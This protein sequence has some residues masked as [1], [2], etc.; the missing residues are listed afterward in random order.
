MTYFHLVASIAMVLPA[1][2]ATGGRADNIPPEQAIEVVRAHEANFLARVRCARWNKKGY[3]GDILNI[4]DPTQ[5]RFDH[6][7]KLWNRTKIVFEPGTGRYRYDCEGVF[8]WHRPDHDLDYVSKKFTLTNDGRAEREYEEGQ[9]G[10]VFP[11]SKPHKDGN[12]AHTDFDRAM[13][14]HGPGGMGWFPPYIWNVR[15][16][17]F[18]ED[19]AAKRKLFKIESQSD[20]TWIIN[21]TP[22]DPYLPEDQCDANLCY[23]PKRGVVLWEELRGT[24]KIRVKA[25]EGKVW[26]R[27]VVIWQ[28]IENDLWVPTRF[29]LFHLSASRIARIEYHDLEI[30]PRVDEK[31][32]TIEFPIGT[33]VVDKI[34]RKTYKITGGVIDEQKA[35]RDFIE[36]ENLAV[37]FEEV[38]KQSNRTIWDRWRYPATAA[39]VLAVILTGVAVWRLRRSR[40][41][42]VIIAITLVSLG[43]T[44]QGAEPDRDGTWKVLHVTSE[45]QGISQCG[46]NTTVFSLEY[47][48]IAYQDS[49]P[50]RSRS[51]CSCPRAGD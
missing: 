26:Q 44:I 50:T 5:I 1:I 37:Q 11:P 48:R 22:L 42:M 17:K 45:G 16:S 47:F 33:Q 4:D 9:P 20:G 35:I 19:R 18:L 8:R 32:F 34:E 2:C 41:L 25:W 30:N 38:V 21:T 15:F 14:L 3:D 6:D 29:D 46:F 27:M 7:P 31:T 13:Q 36:S 43:G 23:D 40:K 39:G 12:I 10:T 51:F 49:V 24:P 28:K